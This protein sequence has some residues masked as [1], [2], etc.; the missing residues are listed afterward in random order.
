MALAKKRGVNLSAMNDVQLQD[1]LLDAVKIS[2]FGNG[3]YDKTNKLT[4]ARGGDWQSVIDSALLFKTY[5]V[6]YYNNM[7]NMFNH[8]N[9]KGLLYTTASILAMGGGKASIPVT[10][11]LGAL[12]ALGITDPDDEEES[13]EYVY[14]LIADV[15]GQETANVAKYGIPSLLGINLSGTYRDTITDALHDGVPD[16]TISISDLPA[17]SIF[18]RFENMKEY[19]FRQPGKMVE[20]ILPAWFASGS[21]AI[22][23]K[24]TG[25]TDRAGRQRKDVNNEYIKPDK[26]DTVLRFLGFNPVSISEKTDRIWTEKK[27]KE[28]Y[29]EQRREIYARYRDY[30][31][32]GDTSD[33][34][35]AQ[36]ALDI[37]EYNAKVARSNRNIPLIDEA[38]LERAA[39]DTE[40]KFLKSSLDEKAQQRREKKE[41]GK[42]VIRNGKLVREEE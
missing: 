33:S 25:V 13:D 38:G 42:I 40:S 23:E 31:K 37:E 22:R 32:S 9:L 2:D 8:K 4:W 15:A 21:R 16:G 28:K 17:Y 24:Y 36:L 29:A 35:L 5:E 12:A 11:L 10:L 34:K 19:G 27:V 18:K 3:V 26:G 20:E 6:N 1:F 30:M 39:K 14:N 41:K 7:W